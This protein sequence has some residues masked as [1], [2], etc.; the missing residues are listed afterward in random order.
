M[1][2]S[3]KGW[4]PLMRRDY[5]EERGEHFEWNADAL[6]SSGIKRVVLREGGA[7]NSTREEVRELVSVFERIH[8]ALQGEQFS[9]DEKEFVVLCAS[10]LIASISAQNQS[11]AGA[12]LRALP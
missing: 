8:K 2:S 1:M 3:L 9:D 7:M 11:T 6:D 12:H 5:D 10:E 4:A